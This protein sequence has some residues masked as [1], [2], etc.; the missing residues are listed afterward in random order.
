MSR[1]TVAGSSPKVLERL[2]LEKEVGELCRIEMQ[3]TGGDLGATAARRSLNA[4]FLEKWDIV[5][6]NSL[7]TRSMLIRLREYVGGQSSNEVARLVMNAASEMYFVGLVAET[8]Q[9]LTE[10]DSPRKLNLARGGRGAVGANWNTLPLKRGRTTLG[11]LTV[12]LD[13][14]RE[15][16][17][18][19]RMK[20]EEMLIKGRHRY[21]V[22]ARSEVDPR[23][24]SEGG[25]ACSLAGASLEGGH[26]SPTLGTLEV[27]VPAEPVFAKIRLLLSLTR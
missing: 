16:F 19:E 22:A 25:W 9:L 2:A 15:R 18:E 27:N 1:R 6:A 14:S 17:E 8:L 4:V 13:L 23:I 3:G 24:L 26:E 10:G 12:V 7:L 21:L 20:R 5:E 11:E